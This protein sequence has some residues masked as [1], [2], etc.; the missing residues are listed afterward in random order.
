[1][2]VP[3][4]QCKCIGEAGEPYEA[5]SWIAGVADRVAVKGN[6]K[7]FVDILAVEDLEGLRKMWSG[8][9]AGFC[10]SLSQRG[11]VANLSG[12]VRAGNG[13]G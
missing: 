7:D 4:K 2:R 8:S 6:A 11:P 12:L 13:A 9:F 1:M 10:H 5:D 3:T